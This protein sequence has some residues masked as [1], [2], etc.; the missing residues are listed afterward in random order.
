M[1]YTVDVTVVGVAPLIQNRY[2][3]PDFGSAGKGGKKVTGSPDYTQEWRTK[4]YADSE[5]RIY[6]PAEHFDGAI[7]KAAVNFKVTGKRGKTYKDLVSASVFV[8]PDFIYH[9]GLTVPEELDTDGDKPIY[10][11]YRPVVVQRA[12]VARARPAF[13]PGWKLNFEL[14]VI[15]DEMPAD[16]LQDI[17][18][19]AGKTVGI[20]DYRPRFG[21]FTLEKFE[22]HR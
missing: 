13:K 14:Q 22:V 17:L 6:Q 16:I 12:R 7:K 11:D 3:M 18:T 5:G 21:R 1:M 8:T 20:G 10:V 2:P 9:D 19:L 15:D 4:F